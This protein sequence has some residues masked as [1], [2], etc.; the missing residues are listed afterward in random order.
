MRTIPQAALELAADHLSQEPDSIAWV[1]TVLALS[2]VS[3]DWHSCV[4]DLSHLDRDTR[5]A[6]LQRSRPF[7]PRM[8]GD[9][10]VVL[11]TEVQPRKG[12]QRRNA[13][14]V[15]LGDVRLVAEQA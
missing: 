3:L 5:R 10:A 6:V 9:V 1:E 15:D 12:D 7:E 14:V 11:Y 8:V 4:R 2:E 13:V